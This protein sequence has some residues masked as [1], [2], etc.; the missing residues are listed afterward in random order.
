M[1]STNMKRYEQWLVQRGKDMN[2]GQHKYDKEKCKYEKIYI[3]EITNMK[4]YTER[5]VKI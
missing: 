1:V 5:L 4:R 2:N 3:M